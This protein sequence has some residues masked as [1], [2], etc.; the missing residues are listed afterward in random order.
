M[1]IDSNK[2]II[3]FSDCIMIDCII[4]FIDCIK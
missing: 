1:D 3:E 2:P 4:E